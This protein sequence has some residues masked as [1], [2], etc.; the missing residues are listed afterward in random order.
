M[1]IRRYAT[2][3]PSGV[4]WLGAV[5][6]HW[7]VIRLRFVAD[8]NPSKS[9]IAALD[10]NTLISFLPMDAVGDDGTINLERERPISELETGY[11]YFRDG[12][13]T[14]A[15]IT[16]CYENGKGAVMRG[17]RGG[18]GFGTTE[19]IVVRPRPD[20]T[21][22]E[23]LHWWFVSTPF[24]QLGESHM[25]GA[26]GQKRLPDD[27]VR[28]FVMA[29]PA[30][31]EQLQIASFLDHET[32]KI[33]ALVDEQRRL[34]DLLKEKRQAVISQAVTKGLDLTVEMKDSGVAWLGMVPAHWDLT[35][36]KFAANVQTGVAKG[37]DN[38]GKS[39]VEVPYLRVANVQDGYLDLDD[40]ASI[41]MPVD[42]V[43]RYL[44]KTGDVLMNEGGDF[45]KL[46]R[47]H[48]WDGSIAPCI[49]QNHV[50]AVRPFDID[51]HWLSVVTGSAYAQFYFMTRSKQSTNLASISSTNIMELP[52]V[53]PPRVEQLELLRALGGELSALDELAN[54]ARHGIRLLQERRAALISA[55]VT[56]K[57]DVRERDDLVAAMADS[58][59]DIA[60][61]RFV[62]ESAQAH[63]ARI[64]ASLMRGD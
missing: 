42:D 45:D 47:G 60:A 25:Y 20:K 29:M 13:V 39:V 22:G 26:G 36:L 48:V 19:L 41:E 63:V 49:H 32:A 62:I 16:P 30:A 23:Y 64:Q 33:D 24:R 43:Q 56:G 4:A 34:I 46:G 53:I 12:D 10:K 2:Y 51:P 58:A 15:K 31:E 3:K 11:T 1:T 38:A 44:L 54:D 28:D 5:P 61:G 59:R 35:R 50:F 27:F 9:E 52:V 40:V 8:L 14:I 17:L 21:T 18:I 55:A 57:I 6:G 37:K 7:D